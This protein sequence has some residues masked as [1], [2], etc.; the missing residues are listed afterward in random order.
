MSH[1]NCKKGQI[2]TIFALAFILILACLKNKTNMSNQIIGGPK[3]VTS[4][5][6][7]IDYANI[8]G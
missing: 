2:D 7:S 1:I 8:M 6:K 5:K 4:I 3:Y